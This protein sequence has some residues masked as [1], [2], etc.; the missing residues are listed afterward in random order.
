MKQFHSKLDTLYEGL[1]LKKTYIPENEKP[2]FTSVDNPFK[3]NDILH[4]VYTMV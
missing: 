4:K 3:L 2:D 1:N